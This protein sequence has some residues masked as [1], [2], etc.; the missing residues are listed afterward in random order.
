MDA[1]KEFEELGLLNCITMAMV[2]DMQINMWT[3]KL[4]MQEKNLES[5]HFHENF[6]IVVNMNFSPSFL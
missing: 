4:G 5:L 1:K 3:N 6:L 2:I